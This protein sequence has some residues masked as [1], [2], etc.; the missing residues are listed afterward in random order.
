MEDVSRKLGSKSISV[1]TLMSRFLKTEE[2][3]VQT[4][5]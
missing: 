4:N 5:R 3:V 2:P 1:Q